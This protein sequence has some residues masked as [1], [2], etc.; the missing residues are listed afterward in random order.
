MIVIVIAPTPVGLVLGF[1]PAPAPALT[2]DVPP[3]SAVTGAMTGVMRF[4]PD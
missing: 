1:A 4:A 3:E 2:F